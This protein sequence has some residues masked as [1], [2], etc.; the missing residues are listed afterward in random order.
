MAERLRVTLNGG[1]EKTL[2]GDAHENW[3]TVMD[4][5]ADWLRLEGGVAM[6]RVSAIASMRI[7]G[8]PD[9]PD[10]EARSAMAERRA[11]KGPPPL[12]DVS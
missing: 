4:G 1:T 8:S 9:D 12:D 10:R 3:Q 7:E 2:A 6:V 5:G 11:A